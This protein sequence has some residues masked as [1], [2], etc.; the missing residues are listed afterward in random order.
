VS[1][2]KVKVIKAV[3][4]VDYEPET[5]AE[6]SQHGPTHHR[7]ASDTFDEVGGGNTVWG[8]V[9]CWGRRSLA[10]V[11]GMLVLVTAAHVPTCA[12]SVQRCHEYCW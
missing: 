9:L 2:K 10:G 4:N 1:E 3:L 5:D 8:C 11:E 12:A 7:Q 6:G